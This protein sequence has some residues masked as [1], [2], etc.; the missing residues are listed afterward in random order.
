MQKFL[1]DFMYTH[2]HTHVYANNFC[3]CIFIYY[4]FMPY[5]NFYNITYIFFIFIFFTY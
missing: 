5:E 4:I 2:T 3:D 1:Q